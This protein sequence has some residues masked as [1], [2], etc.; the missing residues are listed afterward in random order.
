MKIFK[1]TRGN[2]IVEAIKLSWK[3]WC[4]L[5]DNFPDIVSPENPARTSTNFSDTCGE[6]GPDFIELDVMTPLGSMTA[7]HG[8]WIIRHPSGAYNV[9]YPKLF[10][11]MF[12][13]IE[14]PRV[15][16]SSVMKMMSMGKEI[17]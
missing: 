14:K 5:C 11:K 15:F 7:K 16:S 13:E 2:V 3:T 10:L 4:K 9:V 12:V 1:S 17:I 6:V 8:D